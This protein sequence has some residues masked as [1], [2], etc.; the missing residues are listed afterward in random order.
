MKGFKR[1]N[2]LFSLCGLNC[3]LCSMHIGGH[4]GGCGKGNQSCRIAK[5]SL[6]HGN[7]EYCF[8]CPDFP[9]DKYDGIDDSDSFITHKNQK[10]DLE[11]ARLIGIANYNKEQQEKIEILNM[12][13]TQY[14]DGRRKTFFCVAVNLLNIADIKAILNQIN[15]NSE[16]ESLEMKEK[17]AYVAMLFQNL[18]DNQG[19]SL[20]LRKK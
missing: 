16:L 18:A 3:G 14:N 11:K 10:A 1:D 12:L 13:L 19:I 4:C 6:E 9:C 8:D 15:E 2:Q 7:V 5:C 20:K 17:S